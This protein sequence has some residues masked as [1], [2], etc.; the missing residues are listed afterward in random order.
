MPD[1]IVYLERKLFPEEAF[2]NDQDLKNEIMQK[3]EMRL[4]NETSQEKMEVNDI[5]IIEPKETK[6]E[7]SSKKQCPTSK[8]ELKLRDMYA[9]SVNRHDGVSLQAKKSSE[10]T[11]F[12]KFDS[13]GKIYSKDTIEKSSKRRKRRN[14]EKRRLF[15]KKYRKGLIQ[16]KKHKKAQNKTIKNNNFEEKSGKRD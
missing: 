4:S 1:E 6:L 11:R 16:K 7:K 15:A 3:V 13:N 8:I 12:F 2:N 14:L 9:V 10:R 5:F